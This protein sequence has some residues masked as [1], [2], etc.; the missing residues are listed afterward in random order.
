MAEWSGRIGMDD[1]R[2]LARGRRV[3]QKLGIACL[4]VPSSL[5]N[6]SPIL[7]SF[8]SYRARST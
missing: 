6:L 2:S 5:A 8:H 4:Q 7:P 1:W 3:V